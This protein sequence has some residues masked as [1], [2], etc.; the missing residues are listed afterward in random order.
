MNI[1]MNLSAV[2]YW[3]TEEPFVDRFH[4]AGNW[5]AKDATGKDVS[6]TLAL[7]ANGYPTKL[8]GVATLNVMIGMDPQSAAPT[9]EYVLTYSG[10]AGKISISNAHIVSQTA[11]KVVF[12]FTGGD[13]KPA[14][15][16]T[17]SSLDAANP[18]SDVHVVRAD[19]QALFDAGELFNPTFVSKLSQW[20][21]AR[22]MEWEYTNA[23]P[24]VSWAGRSTL[25]SGSWSGVG[26]GNNQGV[27]LEVMVKLANE[28]HVDMWYNVPTK[29][30]NSYVTNALTY[31]RD[32]L[33][34][35]L[36][37]H[38]EWSNEV[39]NTGFAANGYAQGQAN[40][41]WGNGGTVAHG[42]NIYYGYRSAQIA[43]I[44]HQVFTG[45]HAGQAIDVLAGQ[46]AYS[47][48][49]PYML[50]GVAKAGLGSAASLFQA[51][52]VA[53]YFGGEMGLAG[54]NSTDAAKVLSWARGGAAGMDAAFHELEYGGSLHSDW[55]LAVVHNWLT[56]SA[57]AAKSAGLAM[58]AYEGGASLEVTRYSTSVQAE[59]QSFF[60]KMMNDPRMGDLYTKLVADFK[61]TGGTEFVA[62]A[63]VSGSS[64]YGYY[65]VLDSIYSTGSAR[66]DA[67]LA[68]RTDTA[69]APA[70]Q[71]VTPTAGADN[72]TG[73][74][75]GQTIHALAGNDTVTGGTGND[76]FYGE[77][78]ND[79]LVGNGGADWLI[80]GDGNDTQS[81][82]I[83]DDTL[84]GGSGNDVLNGGDGNDRL[85]ADGGY[86]TITGGAGAD[87]F[88]TPAGCATFT[89]TGSSAYATE[90]ITDFTTGVDKLALGF[91]P[92]ALLNGTAA[93]VS[94]AATWASQTLQ[95]HAGTADI[96]AVVVGSDT[97]LFYDDH[98][99]GGAMDAAIK[100]DHIVA[101]GLQLTD[102]A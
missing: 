87:R 64:T 84:Q 12:D 77:A 8:A 53:P 36:K 48:L 52:A 33:D 46:A 69:A 14:A 96:A 59:V 18:I 85:Q 34:P 11:G 15:G 17:F 41:L 65:G 92:V 38:V 57:A 19:Q 55:S 45:T 51:Y 80:G 86:D 76:V 1:G 50:D 4:T 99:A 54:S 47:G 62:Y 75:A 10:T 83:G 31:I 89:T 29:A 25:A 71:A 74:A 44:A 27:P 9:D 24:T 42:A 70:D 7:D 88:V 23:S 13:Y 21:E 58:V 72:I 30:D 61:A 95:A 20:G 16:I 22:F 49:M 40:S 63:D 28:A 26:G 94:A 35:S 73:A 32:N 97:Y 5:L 81:G 68:A 98:G 39:W 90:E 6:S 60:A 3:G 66:Y 100:L 93:S 2:S 78:G 43:D 56:S 37:V 82:G 79:S 91:H 101:G 102:F 67:L